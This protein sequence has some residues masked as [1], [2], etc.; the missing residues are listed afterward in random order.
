M[1]NSDF[2]KRKYVIIQELMIY[3]DFQLISIGLL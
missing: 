1:V 2:I 3:I